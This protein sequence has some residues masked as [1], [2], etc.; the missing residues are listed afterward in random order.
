MEETTVI[1]GG[2][3]GCEAAFTL[4][5]AGCG[6]TLCE[7]KPR[8]LTPAHK[9]PDLFAELVCSNS[10]KAARVNTASGLLKAEM[11]L[12]GSL[13]VEAAESCSVAAGG[14]LAVDRDKFA[15]YITNSIKSHKNIKIV[16]EETVTFPAKNAIIATGPLTSDRFAAAIAKKCG[17]AL[18]FYDAAAPIVTKESVDFSTA[19][20][21]SRYGK[22]G[23]DYINCPFTAEEY[24]RF[25]NEL[26]TAESVIQHG[27]DVYEGCM[28]VEV[29]AKRGK[30]S[31]RYGCMKPVGLTDPRT[32][33]RPYAAVQLRAEN[34]DGSLYNIVGFQTNLRFGEQERVFRMIPGLQNAAFTR[35]GVMHRNTFLDSPKVLNHD[36]S[37][38]DADNIFF[39]GQI[40]G[41][42]G[43]CESAV[44]GIIAAKFLLSRL[45]G[46]EQPPLPATTMCGS[47]ARFISDE[48][49]LR[50]QPI[51]AAMGLLPPLDTNIR[52]KAAR[53]EK[54]AARSLS[55][56]TNWINI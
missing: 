29:L 33:K 32:G 44:G 5:N 27:F 6:V 48:S 36:F 54:L 42:E 50:F 22:G 3:A 53:Y 20:F 39:A 51:G 24:D 11:K 18:S 14:A 23:D 47:L 12:L 49:N 37:L 30:D 17:G 38:R 26:I 35:Y 1:G 43:Y 15:G 19:F 28:P 46:K 34:A 10:L 13:V 56:L 45:V 31:V 2:L 9:S 25:Y 21:A 40:T 8:K 7:M 41:T 16:S 52:D 4:A 55:D